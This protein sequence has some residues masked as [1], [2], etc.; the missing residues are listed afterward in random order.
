[1]AAYAVARESAGLARVTS[2]YVHAVDALTNYQA[3]S[4]TKARELYRAILR[5]PNLAKTKRLPSFCLLHVGMEVRLTT[6]LDM[7][8]AVQGAL[9]T[10]LE[11][12]WANNDAS[13]SAL[14]RSVETPAE[15]MLDHMPV[16][17]IVRLH[18][19]KQTFLPCGPCDECVE[20]CEECERCKTKRTELQGVFA[21]QALHRT[22]QYDGPELE[23]QHVNVSRRQLPLPPANV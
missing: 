6:T 9:G 2:V 23:G 10:V 11:I 20:F 18:D 8:C 5:M 15:I 21:V 19:C 12:V 4:A 7:P 3:P 13:A 22:W 1:M 17:V 16:A 14:N